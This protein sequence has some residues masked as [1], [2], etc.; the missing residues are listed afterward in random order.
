MRTFPDAVTTRKLLL[1]DQ[2]TLDSRLVYTLERESLFRSCRTLSDVGLSDCHVTPAV[3][4]GCRSRACAPAVQSE[5]THRESAVRHIA[6]QLKR[7]QVMVDEATRAKANNV[8]LVG[9]TAKS[10]LCEILTGV[11]GI[12]G[13]RCTKLVV[14][15]FLGVRSRGEAA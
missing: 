14:V 11:T 13:T 1:R 6:R 4:V 3:R 5:C 15:S 10:T 8:L 2:P 12:G 7:Q 9:K